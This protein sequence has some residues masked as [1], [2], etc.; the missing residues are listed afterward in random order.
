MKKVWA[1]ACTVG[2]AM[3]WVFGGLAVLAYIDNHALFWLVAVL[4]LLGL[5]LGVWARLR[6]V[7]LTQDVPVGVRAVPQ[8]TAQA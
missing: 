8:E 7:A 4:S 5:G 2:F 6:V 3:F 1:I